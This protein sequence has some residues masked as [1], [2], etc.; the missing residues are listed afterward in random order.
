MVAEVGKGKMV[1]CWQV[2]IKVTYAPVPFKSEILPQ[3]P[4][5]PFPKTHTIRSFLFEPIKKFPPHC[6]GLEIITGEKLCFN[7]LMYASTEAE[8]LEIGHTWLMGLQHEFR[9]MNCELECNH[10]KNLALSIFDS[11][12]IFE[13]NLPAASINRD[14]VNLIDRIVNA[15]YFSKKFHVQILLFWQLFYEEDKIFNDFNGL[16]NMRIF[17]MYD[18]LVIVNK[19]YYQLRGILKYLCL[20][21]ENDHGERADIS[22]YEN[23]KIEDILNGNLFKDNDY[24]GSRFRA[25]DIN[26]DF[27]ESLPLPKIPILE[28][29]NVKYTNINKY[30]KKTAIPIG[31][32]IKNGIIT[33]HI[34]YLP[35]NKMP[36]DLVIFGKSGSGKTYFLAHLISKLKLKAKKLGILSLNLAKEN[37][38]IYYKGFKVIKYSDE[39]FSVPFFLN[40]EYHN[41]FKRLQET[42]TYICASLGL[43][44]VF[45]KIIY[46]TMV[47]LLEKKGELPEKF[48]I[49][50]RFVEVFMKNNPYGKEEQS[51]LMQAFRNRMNVFDEEKVHKVLK[52]SI[53]L[54]WWIKEWM[55]CEKI[56][57]DLSMCSKFIKLLIVNAIFQIIRTFTKDIEAEE[58]R[59]IIVI[60]EVHA[61]LEKPINTNSD[62]A[63]FI[64]KEQMAKIFSEL[65]KEY[66]S[67]GVGF[68]IADQSPERLFDDVASQPSIKVLFRLDYPNNLIFSEDPKERQ[69]LTQLENRLAL[70]MNGAT[71]EKYLMKSLYFSLNSSSKRIK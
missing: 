57:L 59:Y 65:L 68:I 29:E 21:I 10:C 3:D 46:R 16:Y 1:D 8:A 44:N 20:D 17:V 60:D 4:N 30:F 19:S 5:D 51:N 36:Q 6:Y 2:K 18:P 11:V 9:G 25:E 41:F 71:G 45:E 66:H 55:R 22:T 40:K 47:G 70:V 23:L 39:N 35:I 50:L 48:I 26:L 34:L 24:N 38:E 64:M 52:R 28:N 69:M 32:H 7:F 15:F 56:Y 49:L 67:R 37:Q 58:L 53:H 27:P 63:D 43:K 61:I 13:I 12:K 33:D 54:P 42:A 14:Q 31:N 62:D